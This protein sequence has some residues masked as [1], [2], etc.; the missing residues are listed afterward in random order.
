MKKI[1]SLSIRNGSGFF[2][3]DILKKGVGISCYLGFDKYLEYTTILE[4]QQPR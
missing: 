3:T 1:I 2:E 4:V